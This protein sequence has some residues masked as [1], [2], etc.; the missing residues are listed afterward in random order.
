MRRHMPKRSLTDGR[1]QHSV[2]GA[3]TIVTLHSR[4]I[5]A[6]SPD[7]SQLRATA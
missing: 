1:L 4:R 7:L 2:R 5:A 3:L 6:L